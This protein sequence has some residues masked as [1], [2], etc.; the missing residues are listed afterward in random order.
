MPS[1]NEQLAN[2]LTECDPTTVYILIGFLRSRLSRESML[3]R[4]AYLTDESIPPSG[5][6]ERVKLANRLVQLLGWY[7]S[8][9]VAYVYRRVASG[10]GSKQYYATALAVAKILRKAMSKKDRLE[11]PRTPD[12]AQLEEFII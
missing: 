6:P 2:F 5:S 12:P 9:A 11:L 3:V 1:S 4:K 8:N 7:G 10:E